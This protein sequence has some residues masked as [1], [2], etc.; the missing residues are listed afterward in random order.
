MR[1]LGGSPRNKVVN[2]K[3]AFWPLRYRE[4]SD[5]GGGG[6]KVYYF[7]SPQMTWR[8]ARQDFFTGQSTNPVCILR[9]FASVPIDNALLNRLPTEM[10]CRNFVNKHRL[11]LQVVAKCATRSDMVHCPT[12][13]ALSID[14]RTELR[15]GSFVNKHRLSLQVGPPK[16]VCNV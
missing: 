14:F 16:R 11:R 2:N 12:N 9:N 4:E 8:C 13:N 10:R 6:G 3:R 15:R 5:E 1:P 7:F